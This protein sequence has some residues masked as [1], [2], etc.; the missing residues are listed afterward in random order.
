MLL[1]CTKDR[2]IEVVTRGLLAD[3][4]A[5]PPTGRAAGPQPRGWAAGAPVEG[6]VPGS[7]ECS[8]FARVPSSRAPPPLP[9]TSRLRSSVSV[10]LLG[11]HSSGISDGSRSATPSAVSPVIPWHFLWIPSPCHRTFIFADQFPVR[12]TRFYKIPYGLS[13]DDKRQYNPTLSVMCD[14]GDRRSMTRSDVTAD[15]HLLSD[16]CTEDPAAKFGLWE[17]THSYCRR[18]NL[19]VAVETLGL[20]N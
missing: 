6:C 14:R 15:C 17:I 20:F 11:L 3:G 13:W 9:V 18:W 2:F 16:L 19:I 1:V 8:V 7:S 5:A 12:V 10:C 4:A